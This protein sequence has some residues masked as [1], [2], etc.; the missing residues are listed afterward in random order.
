MQKQT[1]IQDKHF[2]DHTK[3]CPRRGSNTRR[4]NLSVIRAF[5]MKKKMLIIKK[6]SLPIATIVKDS[7]WVLKT[8][9]LSHSY[10][11]F[12]KRAIAFRRAVRCSCNTLSLRCT[13][14]VEHQMEQVILL[15]LRSRPVIQIRLTK[16]Q[17]PLG[18][19]IMSETP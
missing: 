15:Q 2:S 5:R 11:K 1:Q 17:C 10:V 14:C 12:C 4:L 16:L 18:T 7:G 9:C 19:R 13:L 3:V 6:T 8:D